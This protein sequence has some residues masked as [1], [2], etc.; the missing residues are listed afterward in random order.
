MSRLRYG[1]FLIP[2]ALALVIAACGSGRATAPA[3]SPPTQAPEVEATRQAPAMEA[4]ADAGPGPCHTDGTDPGASGR[5]ERQRGPFRRCC[6]A[7]TPAPTGPGRYGGGAPAPDG[8]R[9]LA[10]A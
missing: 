8:L 9:Q 4:A 3:T 5:A 2:L 1:A 6:R 7:F 10:G